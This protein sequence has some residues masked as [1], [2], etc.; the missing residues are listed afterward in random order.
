MC[1]F[2]FHRLLYLFDRCLEIT[3]LSVFFFTNTARYILTER[4]YLKT[5]GTMPKIQY[6][7]KISHFKIRRCHE[8]FCLSVCV[9]MLLL[10]YSITTF[11][12]TLSLLAAHW[13]DHA[14]GI[15]WACVKENFPHGLAG[16]LHSFAPGINRPL[17]NC[18]LTGPSLIPSTSAPC[19][20]QRWSARIR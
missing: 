9:T 7:T 10:Q 8:Y 11:F 14:E 4:T 19:N 16:S 5:Q 6:E 13:I 17:N 1:P 18:W 12:T 3:F 15:S 20:T 2:K